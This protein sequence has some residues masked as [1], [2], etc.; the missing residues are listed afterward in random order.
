MN[1]NNDD[2]GKIIKAHLGET[3]GLITAFRAVQEAYGYLPAETEAIA[4]DIFN[5]SKAEVKG[6]IS[7]YADFHREPKGETVIRVCAAEA[8]QAAGGRKL[9]AAVEK[10]YALK[11]GETSASQDITVEPVY[12]LGLCSCA[13]A[14]LVGDKLVGRADVARINT[15]VER[16]QQE[17]S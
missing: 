7:F 15:A 2:L 14:A 8:C 5:L 11:M 12:C 3:G 4:A 16:R 10:Q 9:Q 6:V 1:A 17:R 13:P